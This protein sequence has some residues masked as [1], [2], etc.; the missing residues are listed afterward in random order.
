[1]PIAVNPLN[2]HSSPKETDQ[3]IAMNVIRS[4]KIHNEFLGRVL[5][6]SLFELRQRAD[7][8]EKARRKIGR[9]KHKNW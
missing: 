8:L 3:S 4:T 9:A 2:S 1:V 6:K 7:K 5:L